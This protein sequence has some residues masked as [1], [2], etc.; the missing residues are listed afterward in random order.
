MTI[1]FPAVFKPV[2]GQPASIYQGFEVLTGEPG[3]VQAAFPLKGPVSGGVFIPFGYIFLDEAGD[4][5]FPG[6]GECLPKEFQ[7][8]S[9]VD[10]IHVTKHRVG[11]KNVHAMWF[12]TQGPFG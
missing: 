1:S 6:W 4:E 12:G 5:C 9:G 3:A 10:R 7:I 11:V 8:P 2:N